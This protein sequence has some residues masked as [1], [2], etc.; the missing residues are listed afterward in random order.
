MFDNIGQKIKTLAKVICWIGIV[1]SVIGAIVLFAVAGSGSGYN[2]DIFSGIYKITAV[3]ILILGPLASWVSSFVH[4]G[5]G[6]LID[7]NKEI[8]VV[9]TEIQTMQTL[10]L[11]FYVMNATGELKK[12]QA[13]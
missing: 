2:R 6:E 8:T 5:F 12:F 10:S 1:T 13:L 4:Y 3:A 9:S 11:L 7:V